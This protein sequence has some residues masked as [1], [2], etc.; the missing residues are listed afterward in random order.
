MNFISFCKTK[1]I[2]YTI[3]ANEDI[4]QSKLEQFDK[5]L[6]KIS[7]YITDYDIEKNNIFNLIVKY[8]IDNR[9]EGFKNIIIEVFDTILPYFDNIIEFINVNK[10]N[11]FKINLYYYYYK[12]ITILNSYYYFAYLIHTIVNKLSEDI[13]SKIISNSDNISE[14]ITSKIISNSDILSEAITSKI[15]SNSDILSEAINDIPLNIKPYIEQYKN[16]HI[17]NTNISDNQKL[18]LLYRI[19]YYKYIINDLRIN[20][21]IKDTFENNIFNINNNN[22]MLEH[23]KKY[24]ININENSFTN[25]G[26]YYKKL[27]EYS[28]KLKQIIEKVNERMV[29][30]EG[31]EGDEGDEEDD[32]DDEDN[33]DVYYLLF[34]LGIANF[35]YNKNNNNNILHDF[36]EYIKSITL[37]LNDKKI[38]I[39]ARYIKTYILPKTDNIQ[40]IS[41]LVEKIFKC[42]DTAINFV[43]SQK[44]IFVID[45][46]SDPN[47]HDNSTNNLNSK[48]FEL[49]MI[50]F[51]YYI[52]IIDI[53][54]Y[55]SS[56]N[57]ITSKD[58]LNNFI[59]NLT[60]Y[61]LTTKKIS[62]ITEINK[63]Y[64]IV[65]YIFYKELVNNNIINDNSI[66]DNS[67]FS[68][69]EIF[70]FNNYSSNF[71]YYYANQINID[72][73]YNFIRSIDKTSKNK[74]NLYTTFK[75]IIELYRKE[76]LRKGGKNKLI[77]THK[78]VNIINK[79]KTIIE[80]IIYFDNNKNKVIKFNK[81]YESLSTFK[82]NKKNKYYYI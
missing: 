12:L 1:R 36:N 78:K 21:N 71:L 15:I 51:S 35:E 42:I 65:L 66:N 28:N 33:E 4:I 58:I 29:I 76:L 30:R 20:V 54:V 22:L 70:D 40:L 59:Y 16:K 45:P 31:D 34:K 53:Y 74:I 61:Q 60:D 69:N 7:I 41:I 68:N 11:I 26:P 27:S 8:I 38:L 19:Y 50:K 67:I 37:F 10:I 55:L 57:I 47:S 24:F 14:D 2:Y 75:L 18:I 44:N 32:E 17:N 73:F 23:I 39:I 77:S 52:Y 80:R 25:G 3:G 6:T 9:K 81:K 43:T 5:Y 56:N 13:T 82:Y 64:Y 46:I 72:K 48:L 79:N 62:N 63:P 49:N